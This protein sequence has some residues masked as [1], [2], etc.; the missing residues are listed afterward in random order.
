MSGRRTGGGCI[1]FGRITHEVDRSNGIAVSP[2]DGYL[3]VAD[4]NNDKIG[5]N[6]KLWRFNLLKD[7]SVE[8]TSRKELF[9]WGSERGPD[10]MAIDVA[11][12]LYVAAGF[13]HSDTAAQT[14]KLYKSGVYVIT[15]EGKLVDFIAFP[16]DMIT[17]CCFGDEDRKTLYITAGHKLWSVQVNTPRYI[18]WPEKR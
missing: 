17:N 10:G 9:D 13:N 4:N 3:F 12:R 6:Q 14:A 5:N 8:L 16:A 11:N 15:L 2:N 18:A 7:G 1:D